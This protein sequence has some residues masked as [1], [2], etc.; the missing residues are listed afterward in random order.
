MTEKIYLSPVA[1]KTVDAKL[2]F[3]LHDILEVDLT[4]ED[5]L[6]LRTVKDRNDL[7]IENVEDAPYA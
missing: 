2:Q 1:S 4:K 5:E 7:K 3:I 6:D